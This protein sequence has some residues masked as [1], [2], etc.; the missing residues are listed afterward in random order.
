MSTLEEQRNTLFAEWT[1]GAAKNVKVIDNLLENLKLTL[2]QISFQPNET[3]VSS[4]IHCRDVLEIGAFFSIE[5][6][7]VDSFERY[8]AQLKVYYF[9]YKDVAGLPES[10]NKYQLI[11]LNLLRLL[12]QNRLA[13]FHTEIE[14]LPL[15]VIQTN[16]FINHPIL[17]EQYLMEGSY[18]KVFLAKSQVP[19]PYY[20][21]FIDVLLNTIRIEV[22]SCLETA[23]DTIAVADAVRLL[24]LSNLN[25]FKKFMTTRQWVLSNDNLKISFP[26]SKDMNPLTAKVASKQIASQIIE[27]AVELEKIV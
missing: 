3:Q 19:S 23:F 25:D 14:L 17:L 1:R 22:A 7:R 20:T 4:L 11:G 5:T 13:E 24:F 26:Q 2:S 15:D 16:S 27:Y 10:T 9:D 21:F 6:Q 8:F 18:N 12:S